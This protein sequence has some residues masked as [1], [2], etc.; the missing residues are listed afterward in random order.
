MKLS[1]FVWS[2]DHIV[3]TNTQITNEGL[4]VLWMNDSAVS[5]NKFQ[6]AFSDL[7][8]QEIRLYHVSALS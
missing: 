7:L 8:Q 2:A 1:E 4:L 6:S 3:T 5:W